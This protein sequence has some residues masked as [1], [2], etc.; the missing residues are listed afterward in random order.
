MDHTLK[1]ISMCGLLAF[2][3]KHINIFRIAFNKNSW[4][5]KMRKFLLW[6]SRIKIYFHDI[7]IDLCYS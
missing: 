5:T 1:N 4:D 7:D 6:L 3:E 2:D